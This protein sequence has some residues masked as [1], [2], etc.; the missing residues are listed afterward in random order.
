MLRAV[1]MASWGAGVGSRGWAPAPNPS[2]QGPTVHTD[3]T[4]ERTG[5]PAVP[6][7]SGRLQGHRGPRQARAR[8]PGLGVQRWWQRQPQGPLG[9]LPAPGAGREPT[10]WATGSPTGQRR[11]LP[12][13]QRHAQPHLEQDPGAEKS[14]E[15][16]QQV[17]P[18][19]Y[20][21][22]A[23]VLSL[24]PAGLWFLT[25]PEP[26]WPGPSMHGARPR[27]GSRPRSPAAVS[28][29]CSSCGLPQVLTHC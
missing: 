10:P 21:N 18:R 29:P 2:A 11:L 4:W 27:L 14:R 9:P 16:S 22:A 19:L 26:Q 12:G 23:P 7:G 24:L 28:G 3:C 15:S 8:R 13:A 25:L 1:Q 6:T 20:L 5:P 17:T